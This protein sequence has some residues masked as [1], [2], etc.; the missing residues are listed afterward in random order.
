MDLLPSPIINTSPLWFNIALFFL[1]VTVI[2]IIRT[3]NYK[4]QISEEKE[5][6]KG[7]NSNERWLKR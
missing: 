5:R 1:M 6:N 2:S 4:K 3:Y 7:L